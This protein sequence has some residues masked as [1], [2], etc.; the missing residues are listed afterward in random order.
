MA[1]GSLHLSEG[2]EDCEWLGTSRAVSLGAGGEGCGGVVG[3]V[4]GALVDRAK[5]LIF[6][7]RYCKLFSLVELFSV[8]NHKI[9]V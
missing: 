2:V 9:M 6:L 7:C 5:A 8:N 3:G 4:V 1:L